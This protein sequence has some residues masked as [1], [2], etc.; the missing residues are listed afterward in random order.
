MDVTVS[1]PD[2][3]D[4]G[5]RVGC[6][7]GPDATTVHATSKPWT[8][9][10]ET[11]VDHVRRVFLDQPDV[12]TYRFLVD[13]EDEILSLTNAEFDLRVRA[14]AAALAERVAP[15][16][17]ALIVC[18]P[19]LDYMV[20][21]FACLY[22][23]VIAVPVYPPNPALLARTLPR[24]VAIVG[25]AQPAV[26]LAPAFITSI[27]DEI[28]ALAPPLGDLHWL[29]VD[30]VDPEVAED[31]RRPDISRR[32]I[33][34]LQYTSGSTGRPKGVM[35]S[36]GN[37]LHNLGSTREA[38]VG[39]YDDSHMVVWLP[40]YHDMGL[41]GGLLQP[42]YSGFAATM[43]SPLAFLK[44]PARWLRAVSRFGGTISGGP[45]FAYDLCVKKTT[46]KDRQGL[47]LSSWR[48]AFCGAEP[49]RSE[50]V[51]TFTQTFA[52]YGFRP[53][54]FYPCYGMAE[55]TLL[56]TGG[57]LKAEPVVRSLD[58]QALMDHRAVDATAGQE[59]RMSVGCGRAASG[60]D[61]A[62]V[63]PETGSRLPDGRVGEIWVSGDSVASGYWRRPEETEQTFSARLPGDSDKS[64]LR[65]GDLGFLDAGELFVTGRIK[66]VIIVAGMNHYPQDIELTVEQSNP[67]LRPGCGVACAVSDDDQDRLVIVHEIDGNPASL[68]V[69]GVMS[70]I[71]AAIAEEHGLQVHEI[72]LIGRGTIPKTS[73]GK[74]QRSAC[75]KAFLEG[76]LKSVARWSSS[77]P[78]TG[79]G[80]GS[81]P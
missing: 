52:P 13:G 32:D 51:A 49:I 48:M 7:S 59:A 77:S 37:L 11:L 34:F 56:V 54:F 20:S 10:S 6:G 69:A 33:A 47:D 16:E 58:A 66:D 3:R 1:M 28:T 22:A 55:A 45:N 44:R 19:G 38:M 15:G 21:F 73:S 53:E 64:Y 60:L 24:L 36:H 81:Q 35:V 46:E 29:A 78:A 4:V 67:A 65:T 41:I 62:V 71:R 70:S 68:D 8:W 50:T 74:L 63:D 75:R 30:Q 14:T 2:P 17:R 40:P 12:A 42:V 39:D 27:A 80:G 9:H 61:V 76:G 26:V 43:M 5:D 57:E 72:V 25:D 23:R 79:P 31:W 18:P